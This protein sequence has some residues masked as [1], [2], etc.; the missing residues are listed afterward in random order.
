M[1]DATPGRAT[2]KNE[3][4][5]YSRLD[6]YAA[7]PMAFKLHYIDK[8]RAEPGVPLK[9][10]KLIHAVLE[11]LVREHMEGERVGPLSEDRAIELYREGW[12]KAGLAGLD[13]FQEGLSILGDFVRDQGVL[14]H[15][16]VLA[17]EKEFR[18]A[19]GPF[20]VLGFIDRVDWV[21]DETVEVIDYKTNRLLFTRDEVDASLQ[22]SLYDLAARQLWPWAK[23]VKLTF[24]MLRHGIRQTTERTPEQLEA[25]CTYVETLGRQTEAAAEFPARLNPNCVWCDHKQDCPAYAGAL[26]GRRDVVCE[27][28]EDLEAVAREREE[29][30]N[31][32]KV[33]YARKKEL[34]KVLKS[35]L[36]D[37]EELTLAGTTYRVF[38]TTKVT[39]PLEQTAEALARDSELSPDEVI[40]RIAVV[41][42]R[43]LKELVKEVTG[44]RARARLLETEL[45]AVAKKSFSPRLWAKAARS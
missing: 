31:L 43:A 7:C 15:K 25:A 33:L 30:S 10:G 39:H 21:D 32:A 13:V 45:E 23:N 19:V 36:R 18:I 22:L 38:N 11:V 3:Y 34:E 8:R 27:D 29:V 41:D 2:F 5:S 16:D 20:T 9:F 17:I 44:G 26:E 40:R 12:A 4:L 14:D 37:H 6:R 1:T 24:N 42:N 35:H 28:L